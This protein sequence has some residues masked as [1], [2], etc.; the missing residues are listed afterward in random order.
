[1]SK[2]GDGYEDVKCQLKFKGCLKNEAGYSRREKYATVG[3]WFDA[4]EN[5]AKAPYEQP[6]GLKGK[7]SAD[8]E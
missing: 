1:M 6:E 4:C 8:P 7:A 3:P 5:C 2:S